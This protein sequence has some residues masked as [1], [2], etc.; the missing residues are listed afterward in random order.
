[1]IGNLRNMHLCR[2][3]ELRAGYSAVKGF[4]VCEY[5]VRFSNLLYYR[6]RFRIYATCWK[7]SVVLQKKRSLYHERESESEDFLTRRVNRI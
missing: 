5:R 1:M 7:R 6:W 4:S 2:K 3:E